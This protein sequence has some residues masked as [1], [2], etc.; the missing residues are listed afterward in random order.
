ML[1][2]E[3]FIARFQTQTKPDTSNHLIMKSFVVSNCALFLVQSPLILGVLLVLLS[4]T[5]A[6]H[7]DKLTSC[8]PEDVLMKR[9]EKL[10]QRSLHAEQ[11]TGRVAT[12]LSCSE[13]SRTDFSSELRNRSLSPWRIV[14][15][16]DTS[17]IPQTYDVAECLCSGCIINGE[18]NTDY[19][20]VPVT[21]S[22]LFLK[23]VPCTTDPQKYS[24][25]YEYKTLPV[26]CTCVVPK[27]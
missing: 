10:R 21:R 9:V 26:A 14:T 3:M 1:R 5:L 25:D 22:V 18:E 23:K 8:L 27:Q 12:E 6:H 24:L 4:V 2:C 20:S 11:I 15:H 13:F 7:K 17:M 16:T 19:N